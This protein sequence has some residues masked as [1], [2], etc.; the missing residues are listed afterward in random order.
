MDLGQSIRKGVKWLIIG[1]TGQ[2]F[3]EFAFGVVMARLLVPADFGLI[4]TIQAFTGFVGMLTTGGMG[5][6]LIRAKTVEMEDFNAVFTLQFGLGLLVYLGFFLAAPGFADFFGE[7]I[8]KDL[9]RVS[10]LTFLL[11]PFTYMHSS[12][13]NREMDFKTRTLI[14]MTTLVVT[15][16]SSIVMALLGWG[17]WSLVLS[18]LV[19][20]LLRN[21][22]L[23]RATPLKLRP[24]FDMSIMRRHGSYGSKIVAN[25]VLSHFRR[26]G[27]KLMLSKLAGPAFLGLFNKA[28]SLH[29]LPYWTLAQP[30]AQ[31][32]FR[33]MAKVQDDLDQT[34]YMYYRVVTLLMVYVLPF[35]IGLLWVAQPF[36][37]VVYGE[38][39]T[40]AGKPLAIMSLSGFFYIIS[41]PCGVVLMAQNRLNQ[42]MVAQIGILAFTLAA[43]AYGLNWGLEGASWGFVLSQVFA[44]FWLYT[45]VYQTLPTR[46]IDLGRAI[47]PGSILNSLLAVV[48]AITDHLSGYLV[49]TKPA[50]YMLLM[51]CSGGLFYL[52]AFFLLPFSSLQTEVARWN[53]IISGGV[54]RLL[55]KP[56]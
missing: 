25:D 46:L 2:R 56:A 24:N 53:R 29:R 52:L 6:A 36:I 48:L 34:K 23:A 27:V 4:V 11:R 35:F 31:P 18:G 41:R 9:M 20:G 49:E 3:L 54:G 43:C 33:A 10:A 44:A 28:D 14:G 13:L 1:N 16:V 21:V 40:A 12:W 15:G 26:E 39:W 38:K 42:E 30:V 45:L 50:L 55:R 37:D 19:G 8:Y 22:L 47:L 17:V 5:Q 32:L 51:I 7:P